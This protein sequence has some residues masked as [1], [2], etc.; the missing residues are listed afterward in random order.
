L[1]PRTP[2]GTCRPGRP[3]GLAAG[4]LGAGWP[5]VYLVVLHKSPPFC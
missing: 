5:G 1:P 4:A 2:G 3:R